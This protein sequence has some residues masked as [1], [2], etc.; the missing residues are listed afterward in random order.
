M[1]SQT[2]VIFVLSKNFYDSPVC[3]CEMGATWV[4]AKEHIPILIPPFGYQD[5]QGVIPL[6]QGLKINEHLKLNLLKEKVEKIFNIQTKI[7]AIDWERKRNKI[8]S[9]IEKNIV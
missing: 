1:S 7:S 9:R 8:V 6:T 5:V 3:L 2:L 4:L